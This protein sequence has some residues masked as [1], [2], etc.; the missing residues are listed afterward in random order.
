[1]SAST[2]G[3]ALL[4]SGLFNYPRRTAQAGEPRVGSPLKTPDVEPLKVF[5]VVIIS[6]WGLSNV[7]F[8]S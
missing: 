1:M 2:P 8:F 5:L 7:F 6:V 4:R 3:S